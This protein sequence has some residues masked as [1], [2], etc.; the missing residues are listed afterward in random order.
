[1]KV[2]KMKKKLHTQEVAMEM[3]EAE[4]EDV[5]QM[6][7]GSKLWKDK[8]FYWRNFLNFEPFSCVPPDVQTPYL[9]LKMVDSIFPA[10]FGHREVKKGLLVLQLLGGVHKTAVLILINA[11]PHQRQSLNF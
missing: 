4:K 11:Y 1:M 3:T 2:A 9:P 5:R 8:I 7:N 6:K 10:T